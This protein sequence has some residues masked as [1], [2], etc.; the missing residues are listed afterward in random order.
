MNQIM[1][2]IQ[3]YYLKVN[4]LKQKD[5]GHNGPYYDEQTLVRVV[6]HEIFIFAYF[7]E[8]TKNQYFLNLM[9]QNANYLISK[10]AIPFD[11]VFYCRKNPHKDL[12]NGVIGQAW[13][14]EG[15]V[16]AYE[17]LKDKRYF[18]K[19]IEIFNNHPFDEKNCV[20]YTLNVDGSIRGI[21]KTFNH[22]LWMAASGFQI[23]SLKDD[24]EVRRKCE[25]F[26]RNI[27]ELHLI[28]NCG[29]IKHPLNISSKKTFFLKG[30][31]F[32]HRIKKMNFNQTFK[33]KENGY[34]LF[35]MY[36]LALIKKYGGSLD[37][38]DSKMFKKELEYSFSNKLIKWLEE[39][40]LSKDINS[41]KNIKHPHMNIYGYPYNAPA[42]E[43]PLIYQQFSSNVGDKK[44]LLD[45][46]WQKQ[47]ELTYDQSKKGFF[48]NTEDSITL[49]A[50][51]YEFVR[52]LD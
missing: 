49:N 36:G 16:K 3:K 37:F 51:L 6:A 31:R 15:L 24:S 5:F 39:D 38:F 13:A 50:R 12:S 1:E 22:Q 8:K 18:D 40:D 17:V 34:H 47:V 25:S 14:I 35:N 30:V 28:Y 48:R 44:D 26:M 33:Y 46:Y 27:S 20:W 9:T 10:E 4:A 32:L 29:L 7:F 2:A 43:L 19:A 42:F 41:M 52:A 23:L 21:D 11:K 45:Y